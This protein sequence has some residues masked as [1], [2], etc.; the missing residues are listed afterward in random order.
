MS[1]KRYEE[2]LPRHLGGW[3]VDASTLRGVRVC[4]VWPQS[5]SVWAFSRVYAGSYISV[6]LSLVLLEKNV[7]GLSTLGPGYSARTVPKPGWK[8]IFLV[9][10]RRC[11]RNDNYAGFIMDCAFFPTPV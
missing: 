10:S 1:A 11:A 8:R 5:G 4:G 7:S 9:P 2:R 6:V 3:A